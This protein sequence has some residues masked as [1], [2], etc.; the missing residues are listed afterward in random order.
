MQN[1][2]RST[3]SI[4]GFSSTRVNPFWTEKTPPHYMLEIF[5]E[6]MAELFAHATLCG[7]WSGSALFANHPLRSLQTKMGWNMFCWIIISFRE[8]SHES[9]EGAASVWGIHVTRWLGTQSLLIF[10]A[11]HKVGFFRIALF[12][13]NGIC[14]NKVQSM[15]KIKLF[16]VV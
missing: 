16:L 7:V 5:L 11:L 6:K 14:S 3:L 2:S 4:S 1:S 15:W 9:L 12:I 8:S 13:P 10:L